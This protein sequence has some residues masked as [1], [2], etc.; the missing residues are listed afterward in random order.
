M[1]DFTPVSILPYFLIMAFIF[2]TAYVF[3]FMMPNDFENENKNKKEIHI[4]LT[5]LRSILA[6]S[7]FF[8]HAVI[9]Y[10][11]YNGYV[12][13]PPPSQFYTLL[14]QL[15]VAIFFSI[16]SFLFWTKAIHLKGKVSY[17][18]LISSRFRRL[19]PAYLLASFVVFLIIAIKS[20]FVIRVPI[21]QLIKECII[22][23][24]TS[25]NVNTINNLNPS[26]L[27]SGAFWTLRYEWKFYFILPIL[28]YALTTQIR[29]RFLIGFV[30]IFI[31]FKVLHN[32][33]SMP[34][35][36]LFIPGMIAAHLF[37]NEKI[38]HK[39]SRFNWLPYVGILSI[40]LIF[41]VCSTAYSYL[42]L[43]LMF[44]FF[45]SV[46]WMPKNF[47][48]YKFLTSKS[49]IILGSI[50]Y[51]TYILHSFI[52]TVFLSYIAKNYPLFFSIGNNFWII[53]FFMSIFVIF[54]SVL[55]FKF[56]E[57]PFMKAI[58]K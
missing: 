37:S 17:R 4:Q 47:F 33:H 30:S 45:V 13:G 31:L 29:L 18:Q 40:S 55:S 3:R 6:L 35:S 48:V 42:S 50:S 54:V 49:S 36:F 11:F 28:A 53:I 22:F 7:V 19:I 57:H 38:R 41:I 27:G 20:D 56:I 8:H 10:Y 32:F 46:L 9:S 44:C 14:G 26:I 23:L 21:H 25:G 5:G 16:T 52:L 15:P 1:L 51:S 43:I 39:I 2:A 34:H 12:W 24:T 58:K